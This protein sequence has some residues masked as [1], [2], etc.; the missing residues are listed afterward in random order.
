[1]YG[2]YVGIFNDGAKD[3]LDDYYDR[4][5]DLFKKYYEMPSLYRTPG[6]WLPLLGESKQMDWGSYL[7]VCSRE[8]VQQLFKLK[9]TGVAPVFE[10]RIGSTR[11]SSTLP[12][13]EWYGIME[14]ECY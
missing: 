13:A 12:K 10:D 9:K 3:N 11:S 7:Y 6:E 5:F 4:P 1:M 2:M 14:V 8:T